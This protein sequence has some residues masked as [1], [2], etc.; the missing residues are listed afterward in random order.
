MASGPVTLATVL[1][2]LGRLQVH[3]R[4]LRR[5]LMD[6]EGY[7]WIT[8]LMLVK[9]LCIRSECLQRPTERKTQ[10]PGFQ[11][12]EGWTVMC[13]ANISGDFTV[14]IAFVLLGALVP[15]SVLFSL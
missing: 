8:L 1:N 4:E 10:A 7:S 15:T 11:G 3:P 9:L 5:K 12:C 13:N 6:E 14:L 2:Y